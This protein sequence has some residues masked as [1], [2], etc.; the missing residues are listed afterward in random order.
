M[1][2]HVNYDTDI[3][4]IVIGP[5]GAPNDL[6]ALSGLAEKAANAGDWELEKLLLKRRKNQIKKVFLNS[7][8]GKNLQ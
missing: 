4:T 8:R 3:L 6:E 1:P 5:P 2:E 7:N